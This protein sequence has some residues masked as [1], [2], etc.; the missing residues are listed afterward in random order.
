MTRRMLS[1]VLLALLTAGC[2]Q[3]STTAPGMVGVT[4]KQ[5]M[6]VSEQEVNQASAQAYQQQ[7]AAA[8]GQGV[9]NSNAAL[10]RRVRAISKRLIA[11]TPYFRPDA[12]Q[13]RWEVNVVQSPEMNA[14]AM[15]G[16]KIA[17]YSGLAQKLSLTDDELAA[18]IGHEI[19]HALR[20]HS[21]EKASQA[22]M[23]QLGVGLLGIIGGLNSNQLG[24]ANSAADLAFGLPY[25]RNMESEADTVGLELM[26]RAGYDPRAAVSVWKKMQMAGQSGGP[27]FL[28]TH[29]NAGQRIESIS[30][31]LPN[32]QPL[33]EAARRK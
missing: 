12:A 25:S 15:A 14:Y 11:Q 17:V 8:R 10:T 21:R 31:Q 9:L 6:L 13:W 26:A 28:S 23:Q 4:R 22:Q 16:G 3:I 30:A 27:G 24:L 18:V 33:Y 32:V 1:W 29:P 7:M 5:T 19:A 20:E 2:Q